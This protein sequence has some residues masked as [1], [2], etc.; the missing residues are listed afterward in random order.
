[1]YDITKIRK[2]LKSK[3]MSIYHS[4]ISYPVTGGNSKTNK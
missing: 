1:M 3:M 2:F 4:R